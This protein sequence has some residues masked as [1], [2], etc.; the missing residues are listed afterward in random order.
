[1]KK[2][3]VKNLPVIAVV[4]WFVAIALIAIYLG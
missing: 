3:I 2:Y 1:M 4:I